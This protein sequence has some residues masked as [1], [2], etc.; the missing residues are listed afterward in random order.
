LKLQALTL[1]NVSSIPTKLHVDGSLNSGVTTKLVGEKKELVG[2]F[3]ALEKEIS[4]EI[5]EATISDY[6]EIFTFTHPLQ[7][8]Q[9]REMWVPATIFYLGPP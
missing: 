4:A 6:S 1:L 8:R 7:G 3:K 9:S 5:P 2:H